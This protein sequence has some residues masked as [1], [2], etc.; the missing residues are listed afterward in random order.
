[1]RLFLKNIFK[2]SREKNTLQ[3]KALSLL[4]VGIFNFIV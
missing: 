4:R 2:Q 1:V 3:Q